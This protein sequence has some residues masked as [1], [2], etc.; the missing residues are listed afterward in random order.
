MMLPELYRHHHAKCAIQFSNSSNGDLLRG[1]LGELPTRAPSAHLDTRKA[2]RVG[3]QINIVSVLMRL[4][5]YVLAVVLAVG[6]RKE[7]LS[8]Q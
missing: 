7:K 2:P 6:K 5:T 1:A 4:A 3:Q 8:R